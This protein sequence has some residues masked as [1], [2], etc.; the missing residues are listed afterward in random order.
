MS[1]LHA[2]G[3]Q[4]VLLPAVAGCLGDLGRDSSHTFCLLRAYTNGVTFPSVSPPTHVWT[5]QPHPR[6]NHSVSPF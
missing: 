4:G 6:Q 3:T 1:L 2:S 5:L